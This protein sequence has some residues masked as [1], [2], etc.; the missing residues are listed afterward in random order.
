MDE[1]AFE[2]PLS[3]YFSDPL[4]VLYS[5]TTD[6]NRSP[7]FT[8]PPPPEESSTSTEGNNSSSSSTDYSDTSN[9]N[10]SSSSNN[11]NSGSGSGS[12]TLIQ[13]NPNYF[14]SFANRRYHFLK[15][16]TASVLRAC[17]QEWLSA[18]EPL[19]ASIHILLWHWIQMDVH[20]DVEARLALLYTF[21]SIHSVGAVIQGLEFHPDSVLN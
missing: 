18:D 14:A 17:P 9:T 2:H 21:N 8:I 12:L 19:P 16:P 4:A 13:N 3:R 6:G 10:A 15:L 5:S 20:M 7:T 1:H 11:N